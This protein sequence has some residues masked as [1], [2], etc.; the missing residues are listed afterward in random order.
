MANRDLVVI[1]GSTG[2]IEPLKIVLS[3]LPVNFPA[4]VLVVIHI[5]SNST[6]IFTTVA[7]AAGP[8][9]VKNAEDGELFKPGQ[10]YLA[11]ANHHLLVID[12]K[13]KLGSGPRENLVRPAID[14][15]FRSAALSRG[16]RVIGIVLSGMLNDGASGLATV[17]RAGGL[18]LVQT[19][20]DSIASEMPL[21]A[22]EATPVDLSAPA[23]DLAQTLIRFV[24]EPAGPSVPIANDVRLE[25][26]IAA[27]GRTDTQLVEKMAHVTAL[28]CPDCGG[29]LSEVN[30]SRPLRFRCQVGHAYTAKTLLSEQED[31]VDEAMRVALR[32][33]EERATLVGKMSADAARTN[34]LG[35]AEMYEERATEYRNHA[36]LLR[37]TILSTM[38]RDKNVQEEK[39]IVDFS[40]KPSK[41]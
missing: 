7:S 32:I 21:A 16:P 23:V 3:M 22:L 33:I 37:K 28:T 39:K 26:D 34:R 2:A 30:D 11:P 14:P 36:E 8:L 41:K 10:V 19:P 29:V 6:G 13:L 38:T 15:L 20:A 5:P 27:G 25:I 31:S 9:P 24:Q 4:S 1:G 40:R 12:N 35:M 18:A 17:K